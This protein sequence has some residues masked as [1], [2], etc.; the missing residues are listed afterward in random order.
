MPKLPKMVRTFRESYPI[1]ILKNYLKNKRKSNQNLTY[2]KNP[3][4]IQN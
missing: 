4:A 3:E 2:N 1:P